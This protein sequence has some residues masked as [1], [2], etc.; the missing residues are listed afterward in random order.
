MGFR[1]YRRKGA[2]LRKRLSGICRLSDAIDRTGLNI[3]DAD[4]A[5]LLKVDKNEWKKEL[6]SIKNLHYPKF[7]DKLPAELKEQVEKL[8]KRLG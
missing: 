3:S 6:D 2:K 1:T 7:G 5:E 8:E 4:M